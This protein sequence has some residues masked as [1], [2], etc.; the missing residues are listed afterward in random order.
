MNINQQREISASQ[1]HI[2]ILHTYIHTQQANTRNLQT[3]AQY[4]YQNI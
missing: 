2:N 4:L 3:Y 1:L